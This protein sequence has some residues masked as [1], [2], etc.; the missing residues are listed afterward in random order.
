MVVLTESAARWLRDMLGDRPEVL[1][2]VLV[3]GVSFAIVQFLVSNFVGPQL[4]DIIAALVSMGC[5]AALLRVW[6]PKEVWLFAHEAA[7]APG[8]TPIRSGPG[9]MQRESNLPGQAVTD[10]H[11][12]ADALDGSGRV[13]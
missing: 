3:C 5:L 4:T 8:A 9:A 13:V 11:R 10:R 6:R 2:V 1:P 12:P 7:A